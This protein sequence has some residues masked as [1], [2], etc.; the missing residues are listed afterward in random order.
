MHNVEIY[1]NQS[2]MKLINYFI[3][4]IS[5]VPSCTVPVV[6]RVGS[7]TTQRIDYVKKNWTAYRVNRLG[8]IVFQIE[9]S[10]FYLNL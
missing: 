3:T 1:C 8:D 10:Y 6:R 2:S 4:Y 5:F 9:Y 7:G